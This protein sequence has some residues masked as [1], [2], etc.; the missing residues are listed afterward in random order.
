M[1]MYVTLSH[2]HSCNNYNKRVICVDYIYLDLYTHFIYVN[3]NCDEISVL[4]C[5][6]LAIV[7]LNL[8]CF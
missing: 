6:S 5:F 1:I 4:N 7:E 8:Y 2:I 3:Q